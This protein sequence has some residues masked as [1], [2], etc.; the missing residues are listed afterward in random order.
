MLRVWKFIERAHQYYIHSRKMPGFLSRKLITFLTRE[1]AG[2]HD[3]QRSLRGNLF[4]RHTRTRTTYIPERC[5][6]FFQKSCRLICRS[7]APFSDKNV[8]D[9]LGGKYRQFFQHKNTGSPSC[10]C[11]VCENLSKGSTSTTYTTEKYLD[12]SPGSWSIFLTRG[13]RW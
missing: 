9:F 7:S 12:F 5:P 13:K 8:D 3:C 11:S 2:R 1:N 10:Q 6:Y 4:K